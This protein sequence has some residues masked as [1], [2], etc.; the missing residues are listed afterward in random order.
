[1]VPNRDLT[2]KY[3]FY[4][5]C[6]LRNLLQFSLALLKTHA[7]TSLEHLVFFG[8][9]TA[10]SPLKMVP[11]SSWYTISKIYPAKPTSDH[12]LKAHLQLGSLWK[13]LSSTDQ[14]V[15]TTASWLIISCFSMRTKHVTAIQ[16]AERSRNSHCTTRILGKS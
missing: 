1:M 11:S 3:F 12:S 7:M 14:H 9:E 13:A 15:V 16:W 8:K 5:F 4:L 6:C 10:W 2:G